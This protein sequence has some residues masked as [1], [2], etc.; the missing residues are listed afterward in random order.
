MSHHSVLIIGSGP[1]GLTAAIYTARANLA[2]LVIEGEP[3]ST[4]D[5]PGG[6]L[7]LTT[8][9][10]N[11]PGFPEGIMGPDL[12]M[13]CREQA[14]RFGAEFLT[15]KV[16]AV[17]FS[18]RPFKVWVRD[19]VHT[20]D[21]VIVSTGAQSLMLGLEAET[22]LLGHGLSTCATC[23]GFF[24]R[25]QLIAVVGGGDSAVE[26]ATFLTKFASKVILVVRRDELRA[27]KIMQER[28]LA[29]PKIELCWNTVV[30]DLLGTDKLEGAI[31]RN[32][33]TGEVTTLP[34]TGLFVAIGHRPNTDLFK[35]VLA[36][37]DN[38]YLITRPGS[39]YTDI[40]GVFA[41]GDVQDHTYRQAITAAGS[42]CMAAIDTERWLESTHHG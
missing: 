30:D 39:S 20:A 35:G 7:M 19:T 31:V 27:S 4:S 6:Q 34:V 38:G 37:E 28:A 36:M 23:D 22:R 11:F 12:M 9:V 18:E 16:T 17:D 42:G 32:V 14:A 40:E 15:E 25:E 5:Q 24:F 41:C 1:A 13:R 26:E 3:S 8:E 10:E 21:A 29:N 2:P 33:V